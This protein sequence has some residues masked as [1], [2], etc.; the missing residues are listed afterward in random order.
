MLNNTY[1]PFPFCPLS[2]SVCLWVQERET[3][4]LLILLSQLLLPCFLPSFS[5]CCGKQVCRDPGFTKDSGSSRPVSL[6][7]TCSCPCR[8][9]PGKCGREEELTTT[10]TAAIVPSWA[11]LLAQ[12][13]WCGVQTALEHFLPPCH[14]R[15]ATATGVGE[16]RSQGQG[17][18]YWAQ[19]GGGTEKSEFLPVSGTYK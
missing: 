7:C 9:Y 5:W 2:L 6:P 18:C 11:C 3:C 16:N 4:V 17:I 1:H 12:P 8:E 14:L 13:N 15:T 19:R 10:I